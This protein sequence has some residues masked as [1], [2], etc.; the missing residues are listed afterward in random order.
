M[1]LECGC[2]EPDSITIDG[3]PIVKIP[4]HS[5]QIDG[6]EGQDAAREISIKRDIL[7][8]NNTVAQHNREHL[9]KHRVFCMNWISAPGSGKTALLEKLITLY[10]A[11]V[12]MFVIE[13]DQQ[14]ANDANRIRQ[15]GAK[16]LQI[17]TGATCHLDA[18]M[19][20]SAL[21]QVDLDEV[22]LLV[23]ENVGNMVCPT[24]YDLGEMM[25]VAVIS[26]PEGDDKPIKYPDLLLTS[27]VL[28]INKTDLIP[29]LDFS[30]DRCIELTKKVN[31]AIK[32]FP[33]SAKTGEGMAEFFEWISSNI[34]QNLL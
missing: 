24:A 22:K 27:Q 13:G 32:V 11:D 9:Q 19:V 16:A 23:I 5:H 28:L 17:N 33:V 26:C 3:K 34:N 15:A 18:E 7:Q 6:Q 30:L 31:P 4:S 8:K 10:G 20:H 14:T 2:S 21:H 1:C 25:K 29:Y 12:P